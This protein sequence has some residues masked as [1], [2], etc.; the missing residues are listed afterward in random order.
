MLDIA[1]RGVARRV[2]S[3]QTYQCDM[4][5][6]GGA[7]I[8][9]PQRR[10]AI[11]TRRAPYL[12]PDGHCPR[13][14]HATPAGTVF[15]NGSASCVLR[16][17]RDAVERDTIYAVI[18]GAAL[19]QTTAAAKVSFTAPSVDGHAQVIAMAQM[20]GGIDPATISYIEAHGTGTR[21]AIRSRSP[22]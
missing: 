10:A 16:R 19:K 5:L 21:S 15:S 8:Q 7:A 1:G 14:R 11:C 6:A 2:Q 22:D 4:A 17:L 3:L 12:A 20:L 9:L 13:V 18:K